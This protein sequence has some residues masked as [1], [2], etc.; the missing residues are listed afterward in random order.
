MKKIQDYLA[1][2]NKTIGQHADDLL[3]Q[4]ELLWN[5]KY[6]PNEHMYFLLKEA[7]L[8]HDD[9][10]ANE[11]FQ[12]RV[13]DKNKKF[14]EEKEISHN[15]LSLFYLNPDAYSTEDY[16]KI[17]CAVLYHHNYCDEVQVIREQKKLI[18]ELLLDEYAYQLKN[19]MVNK[20]FGTAILDSETIVLKGLLH[21]CDYSASGNYQVE[22]PNDFLSISLDQMMRNWKKNNPEAKWNELQ[23]FCMNNRLQNIIAVAPTGMGKTEAGLQWIGDWKGFFILPIRTAINS[24]YDRVR[25]DILHNEKLNER[26]GLLHSESLEYY[27][28]HT[29]ETELLDYYDRGKKF[30]LPL[31]ISTIDQLFDFVFK[32][33]GYE[34]KLVTLAYSKLVIDEIQM[35]GPDLLAYLVCG[36]RQIHKLGG[37]IAVITA[38][39]PPFIRD[40]LIHD[41]EI[42]FKE[43]YFSS[44]QIRHSVF[45]KDTAINAEDILDCYNKNKVEKKGNKILVV[46]N[47]IRKAQA[48]FDVLK[49]SDT[50]LNLHLFH[51]RFTNADKRKLEAEIKKFGS[52]YIENDGIKQLDIQDGIWISTSLVEVS[53][54]IDFDY[55]FTELSDL[56]ALFQR[57]GRCN[58]KGVKKIEGY[59]CFIYCDGT[60]VKCGKTGFIDKT[61]YQCSKDALQEVE[62]F[63]SEADKKKLI[64]TYF[65]TERVK[66]SEFFKEYRRIF[67]EFRDLPVGCFG[68]DKIGALRCIATQNIIPNTVYGQNREE[69]LSREKCM[70]EIELEMEELMLKE[71]KGERYQELY[72]ERLDIQEYLK[73]FVVSIP[74]YEF[75][76][77][78][79]K[80]CETF[81]NVRISRYEKIPVM[82]CHYDEKGFYPIDY[83]TM[84]FKDELMIW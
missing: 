20:I 38:T 27:K 34:M 17:A 18:Q 23:E 70:I 51:S 62:G 80:Y 66:E 46:C 12:S 73:G 7:C 67:E 6:I 22:Y 40:F 61:F 81:G 37:K 83:E 69:I 19:R 77:Y 58:R 44:D 72:A 31:N 52:T 36:I 15:I 21:R 2:P 78:Q 30:T 33:K 39:L 32:Y 42:P 25:T 11:E 45:V 43:K 35:Y 28:N 3:K 75:R 9:G 79:K 53:L 48:L 63:L 50:E 60:Q 41:A 1:K 24:I 16:I 14:N 59:N 5:M 29:Q 10:K 76:K 56:N 26:L 55:L 47:T 68:D 64:D 54:D 13:E 82:A 4:A 71:G 49:K 57:M 8:H 84:P 74:Q 65:T